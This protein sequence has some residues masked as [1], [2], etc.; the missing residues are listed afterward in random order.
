MNTDNPHNFLLM[1][2]IQARSI[3]SGFKEAFLE[4]MP[5]VI[6]QNIILVYNYYNNLGGKTNIIILRAS[7]GPYYCDTFD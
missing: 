4:A 6:V 7:P 2:Q 3:A 5:Q 1:N